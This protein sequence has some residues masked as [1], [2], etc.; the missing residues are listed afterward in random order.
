MK[1]QPN[2]TD[3]KVEMPKQL[4]YVVSI[5][6]G[7]LLIFLPSLSSLVGTA[8]NLIFG[9]F[10]VFAACLQIL[11][12][13]ILRVKKDFSNWVVALS[14]LVIGLFFLLNPNA[15]SSMAAMLFAILAFLS[16]I[17]SLVYASNV[18]SRFKIGLVINGI[19]GIIFALM[20]WANWPDSG[21]SFVGFLIG[22]YLV[23]SGTVRLVFASK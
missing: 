19:V 2:S 13:L 14:F 8:I 7:L 21:L 1:K 22:I 6:I 18:N 10:L 15:V 9:W 20:I 17:S 4:S 11:S 12:L 3:Q 5:I 16:G 23:L